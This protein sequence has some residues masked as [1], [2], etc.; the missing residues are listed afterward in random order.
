MYSTSTTTIAGSHQD[1]APFLC[2]TAIA[3]TVDGMSVEKPQL[4]DLIQR[5]PKDARIAIT[6]E[7]ISPDPARE[8]E[9]IIAIHPDRVQPPRKYHQ[10]LCR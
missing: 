9:P 6:F 4:D 1:M 5:V 8:L 7:K 10:A 3:L 2:A